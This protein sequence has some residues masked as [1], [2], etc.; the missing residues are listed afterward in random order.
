MAN[1]IIVLPKL[2]EAKTIKSILVRNGF[3]VDGVCSTGAQAIQLTEGLP[4]GLI[5]SGYKMNDML[6]SE[7]KECMPVG[8]EMLLLASQKVITED[9]EKDLI[10]LSLPLKVNDLVNTVGMMAEG[11]ERKRKKKQNTVRE[12]ST[13]ENALI[14][15]A[16]KVL[17]IRNHMTEEEAH[18]YLQ[19]SSMDSGVGLSEVA[20]MVLAMMKK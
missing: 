9:F 1:I 10:C 5:I 8:F 11:I 7:L 14:A 12:H 17:I 20:Q 19:K 3:Q 13:Q 18:K 6:F 4:S 16:K 2:E 15:E